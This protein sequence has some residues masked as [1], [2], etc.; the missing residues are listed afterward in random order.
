MIVHIRGQSHGEM[1]NCPIIQIIVPLQSSITSILVPHQHKNRHHNRYCDPS[2]QSRECMSLS[3]CGEI[4][5]LGCDT[6]VIT[7]ILIWLM[8]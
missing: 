6:G 5:S 1:E 7:I 4:L 2:I 3:I 8:K